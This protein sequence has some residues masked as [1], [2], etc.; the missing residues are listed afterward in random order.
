VQF[1]HQ[2]LTLLVEIL[3][4]VEYGMGMVSGLRELAGL[5]WGLGVQ[6]SLHFS[7]LLVEVL[8]RMEYGM[9]MPWQA[10]LKKKCQEVFLFF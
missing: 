8:N 7:T 1:S 9:G 3:N 10:V 6:F 2:F 5:G 4:S